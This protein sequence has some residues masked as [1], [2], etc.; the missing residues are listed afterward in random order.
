[1]SKWHTVTLHHV[2]TEYNVMFD[3]M[4]SVMRYLPEKKTQCKEDLFCVVKIAR[5][6]L[7]K[8]SAKVTPT[9]GMLL[10]SAR[11]VILV[12]KV[13]SF[14]PWDNRMD[15][16]PEDEISYTTQYQVAFLKYVKNEYC[17]KHRGMPVNKHQG[18]PSSNHIFSATPS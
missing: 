2:I 14:R 12:R 9:M 3:P 6:K 17:T 1:M 7:F 10:S 4:D 5:Q 15:I 18:L 8:D 16:N 11:I 13:R